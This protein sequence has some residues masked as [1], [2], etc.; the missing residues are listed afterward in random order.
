MKKVRLGLIGC[1]GRMGAQGHE[2][3]QTEHQA[4]HSLLHDEDT[5]C[6]FF[7]Y[8]LLLIFHWIVTTL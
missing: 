2:K 3:G 6:Y 5:S 1:G 4:G 7:V 8:N